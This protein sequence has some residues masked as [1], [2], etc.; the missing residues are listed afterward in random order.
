M[1]MP[2]MVMP[3]KSKQFARFS[4]RGAASWPRRRR[5]GAASGVAATVAAGDQEPE[6]VVEDVDQASRLRAPRRSPR[7]SEAFLSFS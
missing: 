3:S 7:F 6:V 4:Q 2:I 5:G 1:V